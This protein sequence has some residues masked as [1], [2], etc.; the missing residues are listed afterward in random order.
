M[1]CGTTNKQRRKSKE[2]TFDD[3]PHIIQNLFSKYQDFSDDFSR[4][5]LIALYNEF[6]AFTGN[7]QMTETG[8][9]NIMRSLNVK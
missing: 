6:M 8:F 2:E 7:G 5:D 9:I 4:E 1:L 3:L